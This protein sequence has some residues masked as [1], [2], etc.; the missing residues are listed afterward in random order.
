MKLYI[1]RFIHHIDGLSDFSALKFT[2]SNQYESLI[3]PMVSYLESHGVRF[4]Y[5]TRVTNVVFDIQNGKKLAKK[6]LYEHGGKEE[7]LVC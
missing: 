6:I 2:K 7:C 3:K 1:Q 4:Q 5:D